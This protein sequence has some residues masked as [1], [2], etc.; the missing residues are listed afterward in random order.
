M[1]KKYAERA[2]QLLEQALAL[3]AET[4]RLVRNAVGLMHTELSRQQNGRSNGRVTTVVPFV[5]H[6]TLSVKWQGFACN[7]GATIP[8]RLFDRLCRRPNCFVCH[9]TLLEDVWDGARKSRC[10]VRSTIRRLKRGLEAAGMTGLAQSIQCQ[11]GSYALM[12][13]KRT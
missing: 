4:E 6:D 13:A 5:D 3:Q 11:G 8:L 12:L 10:T 9:E 2:V 7:L 1:E